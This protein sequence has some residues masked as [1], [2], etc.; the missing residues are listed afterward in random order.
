MNYTALSLSQTPPLSVPLPYFLSAPLFLAAA[1]LL[2]LS[3]GADLLATRWSPQMLALTHLV[4]LG[5]LGTVMLGAVQQVVP[6]LIGVPLWRARALAWAVLV[7][8]LPGV[9]LLTV[10]MGGAQAQTAQIGGVLLAAAAGLFLLAVAASLLRARTRHATRPAM[11]LALLALA[12]TVAIAL[13]LLLRFEGLLPLAHPLTR[14]HIGWGAMGWIFLLIVGVAYQVVP[15]FQITPE[16]PRHLRRALAPLS[17]ALL[18]LWSGSHLVPGL[19]WVGGLL[20]LAALLFAAQTLWLQQHRRRRLADVTLD[21]WRLA[22]GSLVL[23]VLAWAALWLWSA[24]W[25]A[26]MVGLLFF[27]GFAAS[28]VS[29]M[30]Y[31]IV[32]FLIW[33]HL[34]NRLQQTGRPQLRVPNMKQVIPERNARWQ[35]RLHLL[36]LFVLAAALPGP[37]WL[38]PA[39]ALVW[40]SS[41]LL[42]GYN[43]L[44][45]LLCYRRTLR[46]AVA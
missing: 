16:Y 28:A 1:A 41:A 30:L 19:V 25:L 46:L 14:L 18:L 35:L 34:N 4:T 6:V 39:A 40:L 23:A 20:G 12:P 21:F 22:M 32:P 27:L 36:A 5:F 8:W 37:H 11:A 33:L 42:L 9:V 17:A 24:A 43:L 3:G 44:L 2:L 13:Y 10:G 7:L 38:T 45:G 31:K 29:G 26:L 15:M